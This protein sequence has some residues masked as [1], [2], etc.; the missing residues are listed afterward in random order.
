MEEEQIK[1]LEFIQNIINRMNSNSFNIKNWMITIVAAMLALY[2]DSYNNVAFIFAA[3]IPTFLFW[4][5]DSYYLQQERKFRKLYDDVISE[6]YKVE[7]FSMP[8]ENYKSC[9]DCKRSVQCKE[10]KCGF[11]NSFFSTPIMILYLSTIILLIILGF[12]LEYK[13]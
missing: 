13:D 11:W 7:P 4:C 5:L 6:N 3:I 9:K 1:H 10:K 8:T 2:A 12:V